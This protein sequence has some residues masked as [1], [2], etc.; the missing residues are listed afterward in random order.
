MCEL[1][2]IGFP[3]DSDVAK[4]AKKKQ[5]EAENPSLAI[6]DTFMAIFGYKRVKEKEEE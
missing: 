5:E 4:Y 6:A 2:N 3:E 1:D